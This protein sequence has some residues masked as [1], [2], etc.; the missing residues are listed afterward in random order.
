MVSETEGAPLGSVTAIH[1]LYSDEGD[2]RM[3]HS[4]PQIAL[5]FS[6]G[7]ILIYRFRANVYVSKAS[8]FRPPVDL[9]EYTEFRECK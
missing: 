7:S 9:S 2:K 6:L 1:I 8:R 3:G 4:D 5:G